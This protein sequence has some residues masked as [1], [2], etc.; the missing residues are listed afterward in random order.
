[1]TGPHRPVTLG[2]DERSHRQQ[3]TRHDPGA[4]DSSDSDSEPVAADHPDYHGRGWHPTKAKPKTKPLLAATAT[5]GA[6]D[7]HARGAQWDVIDTDS[8]DSDDEG[9]G[10]QPLKEVS[11]RR[12]PPAAEPQE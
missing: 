6:S 12:E 7:A 11:T 9:S 5:A 10:R 2:A 4:E 8:S 3:S 1:L